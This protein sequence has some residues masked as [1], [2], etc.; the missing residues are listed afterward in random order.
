MATK[1]FQP[2]FALAQ[3]FWVIALIAI[4][5]AFSQTEGCG[6]HLSKIE[7]IGFSP[8]GSRIVVSR[9]DARDS[10]TSGK[11]YKANVSRTISILDA[12]TGSVIRVVKQDLRAGNCGPA[13]HFW[14]AGRSSVAFH[15]ESQIVVLEFGGGSVTLCAG[16]DARPSRTLKALSHPAAN[17]CMSGD[18]SLLVAG[19][20]G[21]LSIIDPRSDSLL[22]SFQTHEDPFLGSPMFSV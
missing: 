8:C 15:G 14:R 11:F 3:L 9:L 4:L 7:C 1:S 22:H 6:E 21:A 19:G 17:V 5:L 13:F 16:D 20:A 18:G 12:N 2:R 10:M